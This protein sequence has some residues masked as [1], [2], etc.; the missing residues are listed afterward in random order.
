MLSRTQNVLFFTAAVAS[1]VWLSLD[2]VEEVPA[3]RVTG[4]STA[5]SVSIIA[6][7][8]PV[9]RL[10]VSFDSLDCP[11]SRSWW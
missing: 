6:A 4:C 10:S 7:P 8:I 11:M 3:S 9:E 1:E 2:V 5:V